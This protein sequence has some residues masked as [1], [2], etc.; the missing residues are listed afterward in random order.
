[1]KLSCDALQIDASCLAS[2]AGQMSSKVRVEPR[3]DE[4]NTAMAYIR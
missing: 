4:V 3:R 2:L 1:M